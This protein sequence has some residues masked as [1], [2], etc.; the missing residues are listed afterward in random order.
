MSYLRILGLYAFSSARADRDRVALLPT[1]LTNLFIAGTVMR[2]N[3][4]LGRMLPLVSRHF[5]LS[6][7]QYY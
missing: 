4:P 1:T 2:P 7:V 6:A 5:S 3:K